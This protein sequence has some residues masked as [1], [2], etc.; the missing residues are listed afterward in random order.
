MFDLFQTRSCH[1]GCDSHTGFYSLTVDS[2]FDYTSSSTDYST[3]SD[4]T[5]SSISSASI[6]FD[7]DDS[8]LNDSI[9]EA[10]E[11]KPYEYFEDFVGWLAEACS[12]LAIE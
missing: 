7:S 1:K 12:V 8:Y 11:E 9:P 2:T 3:P 5:L 4:R 10:D 6:Y